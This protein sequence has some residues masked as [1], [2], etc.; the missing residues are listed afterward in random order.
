LQDRLRGRFNAFITKLNDSGSALAYSTYL[1]GSTFDI[2]H[3]IAVD[4][5]GNVYITGQT[6]STNFPTERPIQPT[7]GGGFEDGFV[8]KLNESG[9]ALVYSTYLGGGAYDRGTGIAVDRSGSAYVIGYTSST[10]FPTAS[11]LQAANG[12]DFD[13]FVAKLNDSGTELVFSTYLGGSDRDL[14]YGIAV[15]Q[16]GSAYVTGVTLSPNFPTQSPLQGYGGNGDAFVTKM[17]DAGSALF[18]STYLGGRGSDTGIAIAVDALGYA[19]VTGSTTSIDF[20]TESPLQATYGGEG[21]AFISK[22]GSTESAVARTNPG[23]G[24]PTQTPLTDAPSVSSPSNHVGCGA[25]VPAFIPML[26]AFAAR[27]RRARAALKKAI[28]TCGA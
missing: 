10:N 24:Q 25:S 15:D 21:D 14:G 19:Y 18:Y 7:H 28:N 23:S 3:G 12:G 5:A 17:N 13:A 9:S 8:A 22:I 2:A 4:A 20:P 6:E 27:L 16:A 11:P 26:L 1:G